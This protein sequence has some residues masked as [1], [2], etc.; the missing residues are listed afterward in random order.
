MVTHEPK[1]ALSQERFFRSITLDVARAFSSSFILPCRKDCLSFAAEYSAFSDRSP[2][3]LAVSMSL[4]FAGMET[5]FKTS[6]SP[7]N[8]AN[9]ALVMGIFPMNLLLYFSV[10]PQ[11]KPGGQRSAGTPVW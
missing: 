11:G 8:L 3:A 4:I 6:N 9:P 2:C 7:F 10:D 1:T 5:V